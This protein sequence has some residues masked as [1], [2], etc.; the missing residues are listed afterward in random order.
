[1]TLYQSKRAT[2][3][4]AISFCKSSYEKEKLTNSLL[5]TVVAQF[6]AKTTNSERAIYFLLLISYSKNKQ[7]RHMLFTCKNLMFFDFT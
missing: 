6:I 3:G 1:M 4:I 7:K 2:H 5:V